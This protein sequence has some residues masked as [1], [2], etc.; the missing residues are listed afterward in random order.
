[1]DAEYVHDKQAY[2]QIN[3]LINEW[4][5]KRD[6]QELSLYQLNLMKIVFR[7]VTEWWVALLLSL[8]EAY[9]VEVIVYSWK[10]G[11]LKHKW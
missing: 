5:W 10:Q 6:F 9:T 7:D 8:T 3:K 1:M 2:Q 11:N 4:E